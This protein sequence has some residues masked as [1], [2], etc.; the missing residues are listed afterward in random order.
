VSMISRGL[1]ATY[2]SNISLSI[3]MARVYAVSLVCVCYFLATIAV[4][5]DFSRYPA[6]RPA[7]C[8]DPWREPHRG[9][10]GGQARSSL[11]TRRPGIADVPGSGIALAELAEKGADAD[12]AAGHTV[13]RSIG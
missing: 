1:Y 11:S 8:I 4:R 7:A 5:L 12:F 9:R 10:S 2:H 13:R 6:G 3:Y